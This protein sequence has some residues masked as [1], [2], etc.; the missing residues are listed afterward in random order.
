MLIFVTNKVVQLYSTVRYMD[1]FLDQE[2]SWYRGDN[3]SDIT[4]ISSL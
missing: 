3:K 4:R 2:N 1:E